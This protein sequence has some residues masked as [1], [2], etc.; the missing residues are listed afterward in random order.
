MK[1]CKKSH[2]CPYGNA[3]EKNVCAYDENLNEYDVC[4]YLLENWDYIIDELIK[5]RESDNN[6]KNVL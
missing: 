3:F 5:E 4:P 6:V 2:K 1:H